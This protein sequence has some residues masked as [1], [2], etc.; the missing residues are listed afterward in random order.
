MSGVGIG[1]DTVAAGSAV[2]GDSSISVVPKATTDFVVTPEGVALPQPKYSIPSHFVQN[3]NRGGSYGEI[4][5]GRFTERIRL[6]P[7]SP[8]YPTHYHIDLGKE[9]LFPGSSKADP[10]FPKQ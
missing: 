10:G 7:A 1:I 8:K 3:P 9:H 6:D 5:N 4:I 2:V